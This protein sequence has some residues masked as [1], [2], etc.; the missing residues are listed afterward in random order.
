MGNS[1]QSFLRA[2]DNCQ[3][4]GFSLVELMIV[5]GI[6]GVLAT[7]AMPRFQMFQAK[8]RMAE[9]KNML[10]HIYTLEQTYH[11]E[12]NAYRQFAI[13]GRMPNGANNCTQRFGAKLIGFTIEPCDI[14]GPVPRYGYSVN[15]VTNTSFTGHAQTGARRNNFICPGAMAHEFT[16]DQNRNFVGPV[17]PGSTTA[18]R[19]I[20]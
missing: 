13:M 20:P 18:A 10:A 9:G 3:S 15:N 12:T 8:A 19:C 2:L 1:K 5:V 7:L 11:L 14:N 17:V 6:I 16:I 4:K